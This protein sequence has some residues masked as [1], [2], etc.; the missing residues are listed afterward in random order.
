M[1]TEVELKLSF[2]P[3]KLEAIKLHPLIAQA[4]ALG[5]EKLLD[6]IYFDTPDLA[7]HGERMAV[8][9]RRIGERVLQTV[10][11]AAKSVGGLSSRPEWEQDYQAHFDFSRIDVPAVREFLEKRRDTLLPVFSTVFRRE[12]RLAEPRPGVQILLMIDSGKI[13]T[14]D[15]TQ[16]ISE[17]ELELQAGEADDLLAFA[18]DLC[19]DLPLLAQD[20]S[21][22]ER[23]FRLFDDRPER[24]LKAAHV[25]LSGG[26]TAL[27]AFRALVGEA[28]RCWLGNLH[29]AL[30]HENPEFVHQY[31]VI[32]RRL[33]TLFRL[34][35]PI[36]PKDFHTD[37][38]GELKR[39]TVQAGE[40]RDLDVMYES[41]LAPM[42]CSDGD[43]HHEHLVD[44]AIQACQA[45]RR[46]A[47]SQFSQRLDGRPILRFT[48]DQMRLT[49]RRDM[50]AGRFVEKRLSKLY[51]RLVRRH[52][53]ADNNP[54]TENAHRLRIAIKHLRYSCEYFASLYADEDQM[55]D[56]ADRLSELQ[57]DFGFVNDLHQASQR[58]ALWAQSRPDLQAAR[59]Q[60]IHW[61]QPSAERKLSSALAKT[62][63]LLG[64]CQPWCGECERHAESG[65]T[66]R[67]K[68]KAAPVSD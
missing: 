3:E 42:Q 37:W 33:G 5:P 2:P 20:I 60:V 16:P 32:L 35:R 25:R 6:N 36:L 1:A 56:Y 7:L 4:K 57:D 27:D 67:R 23:G 38:A 62:G 55:L 17:L 21:K 28:Q 44:L 39:L 10:K 53:A 61:H 11:C 24:P 47:E 50:P 68:S 51:D 29:G 13:V 31:R 43:P 9:Q 12:T 41:I 19:G 30:L 49:A 15:A 64:R 63:E 66:A 45:A 59:E 65:Q 8:R 58:L 40:I 26:L 52:Y 14:S 54:T 34:F 18:I 46:Q 22:A 48:R